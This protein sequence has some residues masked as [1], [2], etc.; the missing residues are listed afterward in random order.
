M[1]VRGLDERKGLKGNQNIVLENRKK[2]SISGVEDVL[3]FNEESIVLNTTLGIINIKGEGLHINKLNLDDGEVNV[4][5]NIISLQYVG[6]KEDVKA[7]GRG[8]LGK[9]LK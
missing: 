7:K 4:E 2:M 9:M 3:S 6:N 8:I 5:G 1:G